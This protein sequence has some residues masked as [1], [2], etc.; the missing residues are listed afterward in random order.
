MIAYKATKKKLVRAKLK[1]LDQLPQTQNLTRRAHL[2][3]TQTHKLREIHQ[4]NPIIHTTQ[5]FRNPI[6]RCNNECSICKQL[7]T[8]RTTKT[9]I[10]PPINK[11]YNCKSRNVVYLIICKEQTCGTQ[12]VGYT[13]SA[14]LRSG[15]RS[16]RGS[17]GVNHI[18][19]VVTMVTLLV[20]TGHAQLHSSI[21]S[22]R[23]RSHWF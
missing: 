12:Y 20:M 11:D 4:R 10:T 18:H 22:A 13:I 19:I 23:S 16:E 1:P 7:D 8:T 2:T 9:P 17:R 21:A 5:Y 6:K 3:L 15:S 14:S